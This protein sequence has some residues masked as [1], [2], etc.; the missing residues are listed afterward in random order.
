MAV[1]SKDGAWGE[2]YAFTQAVT[3]EVVSVVDAWKAGPEVEAL[4]GAAEKFGAQFVKDV[5]AA[6]CRLAESVLQ[7]CQVPKEVTLTQDH[8]YGALA[9]FGAAVVQEH[10]NIGQ[11]LNALLTAG[12]KADP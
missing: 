8:I 2:H 7:A 12:N 10:L 5:D 11:L 3:G 4:F 1:Y 9:V 6:P